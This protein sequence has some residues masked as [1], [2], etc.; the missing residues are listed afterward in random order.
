[1]PTYKKS[2]QMPKWFDP[3]QVT[4]AAKETQDK[5]AKQEPLQKA[6]ASNLVVISYRDSH[7][8]VVSAEDPSVV[9]QLTQGQQPVDQWGK[10]LQIHRQVKVLA[11]REDM[12]IQAVAELK[13][14]SQQEREMHPS[15]MADSTINRHLQY[16]ALQRLTDFAN[17]MGMY[18]ARARYLNA[19]NASMEGKHFVGFREVTAEISW[20]VGP[21]LK[22]N[23]TATIGIDPGDK[24]VL[25]KTFKDAEGNEHAFTKDAVASLLAGMQFEKPSREVRKRSDIPTYKKPD[26]TNFRA[27][28]KG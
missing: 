16:K 7:G 15:Y 22:K 23:V 1:M 20:L 13:E 19:K 28:S 9:A 21:R 18:G 6:A 2:S 8:H 12:H 11:K 10:P 26:P 17:D 14:V 5:A 25:P 24:F 4:A 3:K 27:I